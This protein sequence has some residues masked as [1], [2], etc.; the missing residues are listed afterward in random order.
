[1][2]VIGEAGLWRLSRR[3]LLGVGALASGHGAARA[4]DDAPRESPLLVFETVSLAARA[5]APGR[6]AVIET[7]AFAKIGDG[8]GARYIRGRGP[9]IAFASA[10]GE[11]WVLD[12]KQPVNALMFGAVADATYDFDSGETRGVDNAPMIQAALDWAMCNM[13][14]TVALPA[15]AYRT[16]DTLHIGYGHG[17]AHTLQLVGGWRSRYGDLPGSILYPTRDDRPAINIQGGRSS[18]I[19]GLSIR[20]RNRPWVVA[21]RVNPM[22][23]APERAAWLDPRLARAGSAPGGLQRHSPYAGVAIDAYGGRAPAD[24]YPRVDYPNW[25]GADPPQYGKTP[26]SDTLI[27]DVEIEGFAVAICNRSNGDGN[28]DFTRIRDC[29]IRYAPVAIAICNTQS[30]N[31]EIRNVTGYGLHTFLTNSGFGVGGTING[32]IDNCEVGNAYQLF[33]IGT[34]SSGPFTV[35]HMH[36]EATVRVGNLTGSGSQCAAV[37]FESCFLN[38][39]NALH[40]QLPA[41]FISTYN[42]QPIALRGCTIRTGGRIANLVVGPAML[43]MRGTLFVGARHMARKTEVEKRAVNFTGGM[44]LGGARFGAGL[45]PQI[46]GLGAGNVGSWIED[47]G[48]LGSTSY[49]SLAVGAPRAPINQFVSGML[50]AGRRSWRLGVGQEPLL[51]LWRQG[52]PTFDGEHMTFVLPPRVQEKFNLDPAPG[53][54]LYHVASGTIFSVMSIGPAT[55]EGITIRSRQLNNISVAPHSDAFVSNDLADKKLDGVTVY[56]STRAVL[57]TEMYYADFIV[58]STLASNVHRGDGCAPDLSRHYQPGDVF[59]SAPADAFARSPIAANSLI[60]SVAAGSPGTLVFS[61]PAVATSQNVP[62]YPIP[63]Y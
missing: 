58:G 42:P 54:L 34:G 45:C 40:G 33:D 63:A 9:V 10:D 44:L 27:E 23:L 5:R 12:P 61:K 7:L 29:R 55:R 25:L 37:T 36:C 47:G 32:P 59:A 3:L 24:A 39:D 22:A 21:Q 19:R 1:M 50:S 60:V 53:D 17:V 49:G 57:P 15:G 38:L 43:D 28:S 48:G 16:D 18:G 20:G 26:S 52:A 11:S 14:P 56:I 6:V 51:R 41:A 8:G 31:V 62:I 35:S 2:Q 30:R 46:V 4:D 13:V